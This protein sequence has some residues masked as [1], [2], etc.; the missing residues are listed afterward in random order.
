MKHKEFLIDD[1]RK[2]E[3]YD[4]AFTS[5]EKYHMYLYMINSKYSISRSSAPIPEAHSIRKTLS[6]SLS[7]RDTLNM[8]FFSNKFV[9]DYL[10]KQPKENQLRLNQ[11]YIL[12]CTSGDLY[13]YHVD[14]ATETNITGLYYANI[15]WRPEWEGETHFSDEKVSEIL[16]TSSFLSGRLVFFDSTIPHKSSQP[17]PDAPYYRFALAVK[18]VRQ[19]DLYGIWNKL[20]NIEDFQYDRNPT[21]TYAEQSLLQYVGSKT[22]H[23]QHSGSTL[24][25]HLYKTFCI[26]KS[27]GASYEAQ[28]AGMFHSAYET[29]YFKHNANFDKEEVIEL[30][31]VY[32]NNLVEY[33]CMPERDRII[34]ENTLSLDNKTLLDLT[35]VSYANAIEQSYRID[36]PE[37][38]FANM[39]DKI[40]NLERPSIC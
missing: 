24:Y 7:L 9:I 29:E 40:K 23:I 20:V 28:L 22:K 30:I 15:D 1:K 37:E 5:A 38:W 31:G 25:E 13:Q 26:L 10:R 17:S 8:G 32:A 21:L 14:S 6:C 34:N 35:Y 33:F 39:K 19:S 18:L 36:I 27:L 11:A 4:D 12:L 2:I 3:V 16:Y